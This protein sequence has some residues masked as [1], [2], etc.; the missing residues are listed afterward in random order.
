MPVQGALIRASDYTDVRKLVSRL[1][2]DRIGEYLSDPE[3]AKYGYGQ[4]V[5]SDGQE[6][7]SETTFIDDLNIATLKSDVIKIA[8]HCGILT[9]P[10]VVG[11]PNV[12]SGD[13]VD[14]NHLDAFLAVLPVLNANRFELGPDQFSDS[15]F[16][17]DISN[18]RTTQWGTS[19]YYGDSTIR[20]S[21]TVDFASSENARY[22][23][24]S[25]G[26]IRFTASRT[27]GS[28]TGQNENWTQLLQAMGTVI[29]NH[30]SCSG[31]TGSGTNIGFYNLTSNPQQVYTK[32]APTGGVYGSAYAQ[33]DYTITMSCNV[34]DNALGQAQLLFVNVYFN[35]DKSGYTP[36]SDTVDGTIT[37]TV[38]V[39]RAT[40]SNVQVAIPNAVNTVLLSS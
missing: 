28:V 1:L 16:P 37:S 30:N 33:N 40:G 13:I 38:N 4:P 3:R 6:V 36:A 22:F 15:T 14:N 5:L 35:D 39:R 21:F 8:A 7:L 18:S 9:D 31:V 19:L 27:G 20:H 26:Q 11:L 10:A 23:F 12:T 24:N 17:T 25:G 2:G 34:P 29:F 32:T